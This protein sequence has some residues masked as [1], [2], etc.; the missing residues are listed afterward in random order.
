MF[1]KKNIKIHTFCSLSFLVCFR[2]AFVYSIVFPSLEPLSF[3][4][5]WRLTA[6]AT[7]LLGRFDFDSTTDPA[8]DVGS[9]KSAGVVDWGDKQWSLHLENT[10]YL[11]S[12]T[13]ATTP[14]ACFR[15]CCLPTYN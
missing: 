1:F 6:H 8:V 5:N 9:N 15:F 3:E 7:E 14:V 10:S 11:L 13:L 2:F 4:K 12:D